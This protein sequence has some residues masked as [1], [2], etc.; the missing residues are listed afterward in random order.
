[1]IK[2]VDDF[3]GLSAHLLKDFPS[4][5]KLTLSRDA[6]NNP[7]LC[8]QE[9]QMFL[10]RLESLTMQVSQPP[11]DTGPQPAFHWARR[12]QR[13]SEELSRHHGLRSLHAARNIGI[14]LQHSGCSP[15]SSAR[16]VR[17]TPRCRRNIGRR[18]TTSPR[19]Q[20]LRQARRPFPGEIPA[21][22]R[23]LLPRRRRGRARVRLHRL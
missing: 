9:L 17:R 13:D 18:S 12:Q 16:V 23:G 15:A 21:G 3:N 4:A 6:I 8:A 22:G 2:T 1:M 11:A 20:R 5:Q 19:P 7:A 10:N 14:P